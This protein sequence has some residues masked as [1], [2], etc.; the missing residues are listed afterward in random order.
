MMLAVIF[1]IF[2]VTSAGQ[3]VTQNKQS[4]MKRLS[5]FRTPVLFV[6]FFLFVWIIV[7]GWRF[8]T[9]ADQAMI[10]EAATDWVGCLL[11]N[12]A[13][14]IQNPGNDTA[15]NVSTVAQWG[16]KQGSGCGMTYPVGVSLPMLTAANVI[17]LFQGVWVFFIFGARIEIYNLWAERLHITSHR[18]DMSVTSASQNKKG[19]GNTGGG[20]RGAGSFIVARKDPTNTYLQMSSSELET[21]KIKSEAD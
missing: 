4:T 16:I 12:F 19:A 8:K 3:A 10:T 5:T 20:T 21:A 18:Y 1:R 13:N 14:G 17:G 2:R 9:Q 7:F 11:L 15:A 6:F